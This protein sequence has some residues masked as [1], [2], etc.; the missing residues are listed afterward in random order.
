M[1]CKQSERNGEA[2]HELEEK[3]QQFNLITQHQ[4]KQMANMEQTN[5]LNTA[6]LLSLLGKEH[7]EPYWY[8]ARYNS[9]QDSWITPEK[10]PVLTF[11]VG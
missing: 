10:I 7:R 1:L 11:T 3:L 6:T 9:L 4:K 8:W 2:L 5:P